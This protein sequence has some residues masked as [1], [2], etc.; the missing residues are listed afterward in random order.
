MKINL[1]STQVLALILVVLGVVT[2]GSAQLTTLVGPMVTQLLVAAASLASSIIS[3]FVLVLTG[4]SNTVLSVQDMPGVE[5]IVVNE[6]ANQTLASLAV[7][8][9]QAKIV[10]S[11]QDQA[12][13]AETAKGN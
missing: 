7:D 5:R 13:V 9:A 2:G 6:R 10:V 8:P 4:Q 11:A 3:G 12:A 1:T